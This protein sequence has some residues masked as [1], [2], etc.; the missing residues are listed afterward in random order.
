MSTKVCFPFIGDSLGGSHISSI[1]LIN[2]LKSYGY[3]VKIVLHEKNTLAKFLK[4]KKIKYD[5]LK[6]K[7]FPNK[8]PYFLK[9]LYFLFMNFF[10][11]RK[12][13]DENKIN[14]VHGNDLKVNL[15]W[16]FSSLKKSKFIWHQRNVIKK[17]SLIQFFILVFS[18]HIIAISETVFNCLNKLLKRKTTIIYNPI[19]KIKI[20]KKP[21]NKKFLNIAFIGKR[22]YEKGFDIF[23]RISE[24]FKKNNK[25]NFN[26]YGL[27]KKILFKKINIITNKFTNIKSIIKKNDI[28][29]ATSRREGFG[30]SLIEFAMAK[31]KNYSIKYC[32]S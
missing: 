18:S 15:C 28:L 25:I 29:V 17:K 24:N 10:T 8:G 2:T 7:K 11:I 3:E 16:G 32:C 6:I 21:N 9:I 1:T 30:R 5:L 13:L 22:K 26:G 4:K 20:L 19:R 14:I 23:L 12:F 31:K 27:E